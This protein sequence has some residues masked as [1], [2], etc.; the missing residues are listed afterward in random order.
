MGLYFTTLIPS[1]FSPSWIYIHRS[2]PS[3]YLPPQANM[4]EFTALVDET[5][6]IGDTKLKEEEG[7]GSHYNDESVATNY[8]SAFFY[9]NVE[10]RDW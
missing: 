7:E 2:T 4:S 9:D 8:E 5:S 3:L 1:T 10:Y 6:C